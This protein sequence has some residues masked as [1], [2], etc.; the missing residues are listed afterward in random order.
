MCVKKRLGLQEHSLLPL[1]APSNAD[2]ENRP[3]S[4]GLCA[5]GRQL[6]P[7]HLNM[8]LN[9][10]ANKYAYKDLSKTPEGLYNLMLNFFKFFFFV[11]V[12]PKIDLFTITHINIPK[13]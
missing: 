12:F 5:A 3:K 9:L 10:A 11:V 2:T 7:R 6:K 1:A 13:A 4:G 8:H